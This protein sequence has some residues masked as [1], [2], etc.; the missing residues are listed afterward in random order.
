MPM[1]WIISAII[2]PVPLIHL[3]LHAMLKFWRKHP[4]IFYALC[5]SMWIGTFLF[6]KPVDEISFF[7]FAPSNNLAMVGFVLI[8]LGVLAV[9][10]S[11]IAL[12]PKRFFMWAVLRPQEVKQIRISSGLFKFIPHPAYIGY[13]F[14]ALGNF[15][16]GGKFYLALVFLFLFALTPIIIYFEEKELTQRVHE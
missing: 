16:A 10:G 1:F 5:I 4:F 14:V 11:I 3:W 15:L 9:T 13:L 12:G 6:F 7:L 8:S 2:T